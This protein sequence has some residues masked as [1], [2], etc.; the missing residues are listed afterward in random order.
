MKNTRSFIFF[1]V[2]CWMD[3]QEVAVAQGRAQLI[4]EIAA[5]SLVAIQSALPEL[6]ARNLTLSG[7][8][9]YVE[10]VNDR[11]VISFLDP[12][13]ARGERSSTEKIGLSVELSED[14]ERVL[15]SFY[16]TR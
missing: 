8:R 2:M 15:R 6:R 4:D 12:N 10:I 16:I 3:T 5:D 7:Y 13:V 9:I 1:A 14:R 11:Y